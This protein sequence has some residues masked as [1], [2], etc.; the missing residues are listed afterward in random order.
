[1]A[2]PLQGLLELLN[3]SQ[4]SSGI[5]MTAVVPGLNLTQM[6]MGVNPTPIK[7]SFDSDAL[8]WGLVHTNARQFKSGFNIHKILHGIDTRQV[9][10]GINMTQIVTGIQPRPLARGLNMRNF[11]PAAYT[12]FPNSIIQLRRGLWIYPTFIF[13]QI[14]SSIACGR[15]SDYIGRRGI[16]LAGSLISFAAF[17][18]TGRVHDGADITGLVR[19]RTLPHNTAQHNNSLP[20]KTNVRA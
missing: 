2:D 8:F 12:E 11:G 10:S 5:N 1:M 19:S 7:S 4:I 17:L 13:T 16:F 6:R 15:L 18:A 20:W 9:L 14:I 3:P